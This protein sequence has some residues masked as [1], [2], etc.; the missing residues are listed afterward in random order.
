MIRRSHALDTLRWPLL[1][2]GGLR[3]RVY[4]LDRLVGGDSIW[5]PVVDSVRTLPSRKRR[6]SW[7]S[8]DGMRIDAIATARPRSGP[9]SWEVG[10]LA[11]DLRSETVVPDI[12]SSVST[13][14][15]RRGGE[16]VFVRAPAD[17]DLVDLARQSGFFPQPRRS[18]VQPA[19][20]RAGQQ[21]RHRPPLASPRGRPRTLP[22]L[23]R[24]HAGRGSSCVGNDDGTVGGIS[25]EAV[26]SAHRHGLRAQRVYPRMAQRDPAG[27]DR[28]DPH[29]R[30]PRRRV[31]LGGARRPCVAQSEG[32]GSHIMARARIPR[33]AEPG[34]RAARRD[35]IRPLHRL[36]PIDR[37]HRKR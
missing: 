23:S 30:P 9:K 24:R 11:F 2:R 36:D 25:G 17:D 19:P 27:R 18:A 20:V 33:P 34:R 7:V 35:R 1:R 31:D 3:N 22:P 32:R 8:A 4:G 10:R 12:L 6:V 29:H 28:T 14:V 13:S 5:R 37:R 16:R 21:A 15:A 26:R